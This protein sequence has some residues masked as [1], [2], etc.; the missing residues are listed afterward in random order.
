MFN[1][2]LLI[3]SWLRISLVVGRICRKGMRLIGQVSFLVEAFRV[4]VLIWI[5]AWTRGL[6]VGKIALRLNLVIAK[7]SIR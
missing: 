6:L 3:R 5:L 4:G 7:C 1:S 2:N